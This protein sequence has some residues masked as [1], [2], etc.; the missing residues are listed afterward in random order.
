MS[1]YPPNDQPPPPPPLNHPDPN[2][3]YGEADHKLVWSILITLFCCQPLG[4]VAIVFSAM[5]MGA[6]NAGDYATAHRHAGVASACIN[7]AVG[8]WLA[9]VV[10][11]LFCVC[12]GVIAGG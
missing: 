9:A 11:W 8:L 3:Y 2:R 1:H 6:N 5:A 10:V 7:W 4:I 12:A